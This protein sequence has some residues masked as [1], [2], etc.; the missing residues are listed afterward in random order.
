MHK[1]VLVEKKYSTRTEEK[2]HELVIASS[3][4]LSFKKSFIIILV[5]HKDEE[6]Y[7]ATP[8]V[9]QDLRVYG[10]FLK[11]FCRRLR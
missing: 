1:F 10:D 7:R 2:L 3:K 8:A 5:F 9:T 11:V 6:L 4:K